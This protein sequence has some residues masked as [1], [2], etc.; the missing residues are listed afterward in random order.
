[1]MNT[2]HFKTVKNKNTSKSTEVPTSNLF[3]HWSDHMIH[4]DPKRLSL[5]SAVG[6]SFFMEEK[7]NLLIKKLGFAWPRCLEKNPTTYSPHGG[8]FNGDESHGRIRK[9]WPTQQIRGRFSSPGD[10]AFYRFF[11]V[12]ERLMVLMVDLMWWIS[13]SRKMGKNFW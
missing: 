1:M 12:G 13:L 2:S 5:R 8:G 4:R 10:D 7:V 9:N 6:L 3:G 11:E